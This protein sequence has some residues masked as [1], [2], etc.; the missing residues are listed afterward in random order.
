MYTT[1]I[2]T[3]LSPHGAHVYMYETFDRVH[4]YVDAV[5]SAPVLKFPF[6]YAA[7]RVVGV[8]KAME[9]IGDN[10]SKSRSSSSSGIRNAASGVV[11][12][13]VVV[14][15]VAL[16]IGIVAVPMV[17]IVMVVITAIIIL[18]IVVLYSPSCSRKLRERISCECCD[19]Y[20]A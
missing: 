18:V 16:V 9:E 8:A 19:M 3:L 10:R 5:L 11:V 1:L 2:C 4:A 20:F 12:S 14:A 6:T 15:L 17:V 13:V 7:A